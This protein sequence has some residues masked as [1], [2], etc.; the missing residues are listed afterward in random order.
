MNADHVGTPRVSI[1]IPTYNQDISLIRACI[2]SCLE[3]SFENLEIIVSDNHSTNEVPAFLSSLDRSKIRI[4]SPPQHVSMKENFDFCASHSS[5]EF[6]S[7]LSSDD[8]LFPNSIQKLVEALERFPNAGFAFGNVLRHET[9]LVG[10]FAQHLIRKPGR[11]SPRQIGGDEALAFFFPWRHQSTWMVGNLL[12]RSVY[13]RTGGLAR[14]TL[15]VAADVWLTRRL[16]SEGD[17]VYVDEP[18]ALF[19]S[20]PVKHEVI[21]P[22]R[23]VCEIMD[24]VRM[25]NDSPVVAVSTRIFQFARLIHALGIDVRTSNDVKQRAAD[26]FASTGRWGLAAC[27]RLSLYSP[28]TVRCLAKGLFLPRLLWRRRGL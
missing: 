5:A 19:R 15:E 10:D 6:V 18:L 26:F 25:S 12:R 28:S 9:M 24:S 20:R 17:F 1:L 22:D 3:Q 21:E 8:M 7:F 27:C 11:A 13:G 4:V 14:S 23:G 16:L 2:E